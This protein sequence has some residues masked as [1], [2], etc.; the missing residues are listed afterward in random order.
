MN[1]N[2]LYKLLLS[3]TLITS[4]LVCLFNDDLTAYRPLIIMIFL[5]L[6]SKLKKL[7]MIKYYRGKYRN[8]IDSSIFLS[9]NLNNNI[10]IILDLI[11]G[12]SFYEGG[13]FIGNSPKKLLNK[14]KQ[15]E[16]IL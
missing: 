2:S 7:N 3:N 9:K 11:F 4:F 16:A 15:Y 10:V 14:I 6:L 13:F 8:R 12:K 1:K 5:V